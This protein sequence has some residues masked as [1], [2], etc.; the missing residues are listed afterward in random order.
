MDL[1]RFDADPDRDPIFH[2]DADP[3]PIASFS[4]VGKKSEEK[5]LTSIN[6]SASSHC[7]QRYRSQNFQ[8]FRQF[9][10]IIWKK[11]KYV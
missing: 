3:D 1:Q 5:N 10:E 8:Y 6:S 7:L 9:T 11:V 2:S 4:H